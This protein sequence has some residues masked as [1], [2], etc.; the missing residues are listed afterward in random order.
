MRWLLTADT[1]SAED[2]RECRVVTEVV[3]S[4]PLERAVEIAQVIATQAPLAVQETLAS[5]RQARISTEQEH[6]NLPARLGR[7]MA[8][9]DVKRGLEAFMTKQPARFQGD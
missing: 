7:L 6:A 5:A 1:F 2:A 8:T 3:D 9:Q 4:D